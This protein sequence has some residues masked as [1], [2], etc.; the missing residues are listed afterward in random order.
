MGFS[1]GEVIEA[2]APVLVPSVEELY[3]QQYAP[4]LGVRLDEE[5]RELLL[6]GE[7]SKDV[8]SYSHEVIESSIDSHVGG[9]QQL[10]PT[11]TPIAHPDAEQLTP[12]LLEDVAYYAE[13]F[14]GHSSIP[15]ELPYVIPQLVVTADEQTVLY[16]DSVLPVPSPFAIPEPTVEKGQHKVVVNPLNNFD[17]LFGDSVMAIPSIESLYGEQQT[18]LAFEAFNFYPQVQAVEGSFAFYEGF[19]PVAEPAHYTTPSVFKNKEVVYTAQNQD[20]LYGF[21]P[22]VAPSHPEQVAPMVAPS[23]PEQV[24]PTLEGEDVTLTDSTFDSVSYGLFKGNGQ[25]A[26]P[27]LIPSIVPQLTPVLVEGTK[28]DSFQAW[29]PVISPETFAIPQLVV[30]ADEQV[31]LYGNSVIAT[32]STYAVPTLTKG[33]DKVVYTPQNQD[34]LSGNSVMAVPSIQELYGVQ[35]PALAF[36]EHVFQPSVQAVEG[37]LETLEGTN[38]GFL[39]GGRDVVE[40]GQQNFF[41]TERTEAPYQLDTM[42][43]VPE[44]PSI[45]SKERGFFSVEEAQAPYSVSTT[46]KT[47]VLSPLPYAIPQLV[48]TA[49]EQTVLYGNSV[50]ATPSHPEQVSPDHTPTATPIA[51]PSAIPHT[52]KGKGKI[53]VNPLDNSDVLYG[54]SVLAIPSIESLYGVQEEAQPYNSPSQPEELVEAPT[55]EAAIQM[56]T[57]ASLTISIGN[58]NLGY[59]D[60]Y[61]NVV[62][63]ESADQIPYDVTLTNAPYTVEVEQLIPQPLEFVEPTATPNAFPDAIQLTPYIKEIMESLVDGYYPTEGSEAPYNMQVSQRAPQQTYPSDKT[64]Q[65][66]TWFQYAEPKEIPGWVD[67]FNAAREEYLAGLSAEGRNVRNVKVTIPTWLTVDH[68]EYS[69]SFLQLLQPTAIPTWLTIALRNR[70]MTESNRELSS[71]RDHS[72]KIESEHN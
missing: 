34:V 6:S 45:D 42:Q 12:I 47:P 35:E 2:F 9:V 68:S 43:R 69:N 50:L 4:L 59:T 20:V 60:I 18:P 32:P 5:Q 16:G 39:A 61:G 13:S 58:T 28:G 27:N 14:S 22:V 57:P 71:E 49:D 46:Q 24:A 40:L 53:I 52:N 44:T 37:T 25:Q 67:E 10:E 21:S 8:V 48:V 23:H 17:T 1:E 72:K 54:N 62:E 63:V 41:P 26:V 19:S 11:A 66:I 29:S 56:L 38:F 15:S 65:K 36:E 7:T 33:K 3:G 64:T 51:N 31:V 55:E 70:G 30:T